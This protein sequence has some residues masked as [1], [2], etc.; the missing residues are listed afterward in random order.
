MNNQSISD[1]FIDAMARLRE[2]DQYTGND[3]P[4]RHHVRMLK[5]CAE[6]GIEDACNN[7]IRLA[8]LARDLPKESRDIAAEAVKA[9]TTKGA[10]Q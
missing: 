2:L 4:M 6:R 5:G 3:E 10:G 7:A 1:L 8:Q 9:A